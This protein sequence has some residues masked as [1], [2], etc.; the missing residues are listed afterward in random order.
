MKRPGAIWPTCTHSPRL[1]SASSGCIC[2]MRRVGYL[3]PK[4]TTYTDQERAAAT[5]IACLIYPDYPSGPDLTTDAAAI[6]EM[7]QNAIDTVRDPYNDASFLAQHTG[8]S[9][10]S[11]KV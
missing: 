7:W 2:R 8:K 10:D 6:G 3:M 1:C 9:Y 5:I 4:Q 11:P